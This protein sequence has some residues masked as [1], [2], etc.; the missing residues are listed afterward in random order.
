MRVQSRQHVGLA[1]GGCCRA[2]GGPPLTRHCPLPVVQ[3]PASAP[4]S[5]SAIEAVLRTSSTHMDQLFWGGIWP[6]L[7]AAGWS[8]DVAAAPHG[9]PLFYPPLAPSTSTSQPAGLAGVHAVLQ[10]LQHHSG[11]LLGGGASTADPPP[12]APGSGG[13]GGAP[14]AATTVGPRLG[15]GTPPG[16]KVCENCGT[17]TT[18]LWRKD[19]QT[20]MMMC[21]AC[22]IFF[23]HHQKHRCTAPAPPA[24][25]CLP[26]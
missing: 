24:C 5:A 11:L 23:K 9:A 4:I 21:N 18:P 12:E 3:V 22:G 25:C 2:V 14:A 7:E 6:Q 26:A 19:R 1:L 16:V 10:H 8:A 20:G 13:G 15:A 17:T